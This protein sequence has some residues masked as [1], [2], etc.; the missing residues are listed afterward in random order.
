MR[1]LR[2]WTQTAIGYLTSQPVRANLPTAHFM[3]GPSKGRP[4]PQL[5][6][7][8]K[9]GLNKPNSPESNSRR[10]N[11]RTERKYEKNRDRTTG[12]RRASASKRCRMADGPDQG[13][14]QSQS[15]KENGHAR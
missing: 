2:Y 8:T 9:R 12:M 4:W 5:W 13:P 11:E 6:R 15:R 10:G 7:A 3:A 1:M 14:G